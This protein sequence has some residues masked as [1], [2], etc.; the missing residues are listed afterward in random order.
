MRIGVVFPGQGSQNVG[1]GVDVALA[2]PA[3]RTCFERANAVLGYDLL[4]LVREGPEEKLRE[5]QY[6]Q[7]AIFTTN[8]ALYSAV[9]AV[10]EPTVGAGHSFGEFCSLVAANSLTFEEALRIVDERGKAMQ[11]AA[12]GARGAMSAV[13]GLPAERVRTVVDE[14]AA[15][16]GGL[17]QL[18]NFNSPTQIVISGEF[19]AVGRA[20]EAML[21]AG[22]KRV[23]PLNV[24]GA[25]HSKLMEPAVARFAAAIDRGAFSVP[26]FDVVSNV[27]ALP[28]RDVAT[29]KQNLVKSIVQEV[30]WHDTAERLLSY[31]LDLVVEFGASAV[32]G[33]LMRRM[34][35][36]PAVMVVSDYAGVEKLRRT[37]LD[38]KEGFVG[39][40]A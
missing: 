25:W 14:L 24:S 5:T 3:A 15:A 16:G 23:V 21:A 36:A 6:S 19:D 20:G 27:D 40:N 18:A 37:I 28:Y 1:M 12:E 4:E 38:A 22:A 9:G 29:I 31:G 26:R 10:L 17:V 7:P 33:P 34:T 30:R 35:G 32:L 2:A 39:V 13:L 11:A 8:V